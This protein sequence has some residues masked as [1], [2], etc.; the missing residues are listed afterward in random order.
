MLSLIRLSLRHLVM[1]AVVV[2]RCRIARKRAQ[3]RPP[4][5][6]ASAMTNGLVSCAI[7]AWA[8]AIGAIGVIVLKSAVAGPGRKRLFELLNATN[9]PLTAFT[10]PASLCDIYLYICKRTR[11][12]S[13]PCIE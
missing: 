13:L 9:V 7:N 12:F 4:V 1:N 5:A 2:G 3:I 10:D 8:G 6:F 11:S